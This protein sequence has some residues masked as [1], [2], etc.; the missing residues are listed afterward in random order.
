[1]QT[2]CDIPRPTVGRGLQAKALD[3][4]QP[5][6]NAPGFA[7]PPRDGSERRAAGHGRCRT[8]K[9]RLRGKGS[10][11]EILSS[12][13]CKPTGQLLRS[14]LIPNSLERSAENGMQQAR[15]GPS[16]SRARQTGDAQ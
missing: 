13:Q 3:E 16:R 2:S 15:T 7:H 4:A 5:D 1:M 6:S 10:Q 12:R 11:I 8:I 14:L 9:D